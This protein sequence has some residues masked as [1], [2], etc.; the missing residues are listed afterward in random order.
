MPFIP[1]RRKIFLNIPSTFVDH[2]FEEIDESRSITEKTQETSE[3][4]TPIPVPMAEAFEISFKRNVCLSESPRQRGESNLYQK[5]R[6]HHPVDLLVLNSGNFDDVVKD[7]FSRNML[8]NA[9]ESYY[10][11]FY[12]PT[13]V[14]H[15]LNT[16]KKHIRLY[17]SYS[18]FVEGQQ[19][20]RSLN[21]EG[22]KE[23]FFISGRVGKGN[24][25][26]ALLISKQ[27][28]NGETHNFVIKIDKCKYSVNWECY[29]HTVVRKSLKCF[30]LNLS[31]FIRCIIGFWHSIH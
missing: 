7:I 19:P 14:F 23:E 21:I 29:I 22:R 9:I 31:N 10:R 24:F 3:L 6:K 20:I 1:N 25:G 15:G 13:N 26:Q 5:E 28:E 2:I 18:F 17:Q 30:E 12:Y 8:V 11:V 4:R 16:A 27:E